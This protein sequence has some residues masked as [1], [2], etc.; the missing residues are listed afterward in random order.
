LLV[1]VT[2]LDAFFA[3]VP[4]GPN[5]L[6]IDVEGH[7]L[8]V[9]EGARQTLEKHRPTILLECEARHRADGDVRPVFDLLHSLD[10]E[11]SFFQGRTRRPLADFEAA[12]HQRLNPSDPERLPRN[13]VNNFAFVQA[14]GPL[15]K[16]SR[17]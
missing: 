3:D 9:L 17:E 14:T 7:E 8:A 5:F 10:Y 4:R 16:H 11:G 13:Y 2:T 6:K 15:P 12:V 1:N